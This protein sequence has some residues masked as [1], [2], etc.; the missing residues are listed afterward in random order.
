MAEYTSKTIA[1]LLNE[2]E[3]GKLV[4]PAIQRNFVWAEEKVCDLFDS[5]MRDYPIG[6][7]LFWEVDN[8]TVCEYVFNE[9]ID[10]YDEQSALQR[11]KRVDG[12]RTE[13]IGVLDGQQRI[14]SLYLG[15]KGYYRTR[16]KGRRRDDASSYVKRFLCMNILHNPD[17]EE[18]KYKFAFVNEQEIEKVTVDSLGNNEF[19]VKVASIVKDDFDAADYVEEIEAKHFSG[20]LPQ[21]IRKKAREM[22]NTL[23]A[24]YKIKLNVTYYP[25]QGKDLGQVVDIFVRVNSGGQKLSASDLM[26]SVATGEQGEE[27]IQI[28]IREAIDTISAAT[29]NTETGFL[30][31]KEL[32]LTAGL[33]CTGANSLSLQ[34]KEN[35]QRVRINAI[36]EKWDDIVDAISNAA[37]F[38]ERIG[39]NGRKLTSKNLLLPIA[40]YFY[41]NKLDDKHASS[42]KLRARRD[43]VYIRQWLLRAMIN[44]IFRDG[45]GSTLISIRNVIDV[46][47]QQYF[48][49]DRLMNASG[50]RSLIISDD[51]VE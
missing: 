7:F 47:G 41:I 33:L 10:C 2:I 16:I 38:I 21:T 22:L 15:F 19:W 25:A 6:T 45:T 28:K 20:T 23:S 35:Y 12:T 46:Y 24:A 27:D 42:L 51:K 1:Y 48:P 43:R 17:T 34:K 14:T 8:D 11:G 3:K 31:D 32:I 49:L 9:F 30:A 18:E 4:L 44:S 40:Y 5:I 50:A 26:L 29:T 13:Y 37:Q 36:L 39:F